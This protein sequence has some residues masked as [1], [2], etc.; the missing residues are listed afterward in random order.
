[1]QDC[2][3]G[4]GNQACADRQCDGHGAQGSEL[5]GVSL[6]R[7]PTCTTPFFFQ[8]SFQERM[9]KRSLS[10]RETAVG[11]NE[12][13]TRIT[14]A[15]GND[16]DSTS[17]AVSADGSKIVFSSDSD[18]LNQGIVDGQ[19]EIWLYDT[20]TD[21]L[22]RITTASA[23]DRS[24]SKPSISGDGTKIVFRSDSDFLNQGITRY[25]FQ[26]WLYDVTTQNLT[27]VTT[28][29]VS[30]RNADRPY[31]SSDGN[32]IV[33]NGDFYVQGSP[34]N[35][36]EIWLYKVGS[37]DLTRLTT[38]SSSDRLSIS[39]R[40][41]SDGSK[42]VF[43]SDSD[44]LNQGIPSDQPEIWLMDVGAMDLTRI[45]TASEFGRWSL[46]PDIDDNGNNV[47]FES[48]SDFLGQGLNHTEIWHYDVNTTALSRITTAAPALV[49]IAESSA[50]R[51][52]GN[53]R[54]IVFESLNDFTGQNRM[55]MSEIWLYDMV[56]HN[57]ER[58]TYAPDGISDSNTASFVPDINMI[59]SS[60]VFHSSVDFTNGTTQ[61]MPNE[62]WLSERTIPQAEITLNYSSG[63]P[64]SYFSVTGENFPAT[65]DGDDGGE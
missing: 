54:Y 7:L 49:P 58:L 41:N 1:M 38:A 10:G 61:K 19:N 20:T 40:T 27:R 28:A 11:D 30:V 2:Q 39:P 5:V 35:L 53:G 23:S 47:V 55:G 32:R 15:S 21:A 43:V 26:I 44:F 31:I 12:N 50:P 63:A 29:S 46:A 52:S 13:L 42:V 59:G 14:Y 4:G 48:D 25:Q 51:I 37:G 18:F 64:S 3:C 8:F 16:R 56:S 34:D 22:Q 36:R 6:M 62:V 65:C 60:I 33:F 17:A 45:T 9:M 57:V 24:S